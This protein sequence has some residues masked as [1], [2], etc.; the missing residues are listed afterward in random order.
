M[1][2]LS[3]Y[4][5][6]SLASIIIRQFLLPNP[7][8]CFGDSAVLYNWIAEPILQ[9]L[10]YMLVGLVYC[11]GSLPSW[12]SLLYLLTYSMLVG[13]LLLFSIFSFVWWW[14]L[15]ITIALII[16]IAGIIIIINALIERR[17]YYD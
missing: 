8:E 12:G 17:G 1:K 7:F 5:T 9:M 13:I 16:V 4:G 10:S 3:L 15:V 6:I 14:V 2:K 11:K